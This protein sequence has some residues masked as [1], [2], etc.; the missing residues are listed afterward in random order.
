MKEEIVTFGT[1]HQMVG[2]LS[3]TE[4]SSKRPVV[5]MFNSGFLH[6][7]GPFRLWVDCARA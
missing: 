4:D 6:R 1:N 2:V 5:L 7:V 3:A